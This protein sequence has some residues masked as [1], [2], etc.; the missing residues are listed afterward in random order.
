MVN[1]SEI[2]DGFVFSFPAV[3]FDCKL[4]R[5]SGRVESSELQ[6]TFWPLPLLYLYLRSSNTNRC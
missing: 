5:V 3:C 4:K 6:N 2:V 1:F